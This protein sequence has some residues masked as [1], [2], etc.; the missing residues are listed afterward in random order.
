M[1]EDEL[2]FS[3]PLPDLERVQVAIDDVKD[4]E[5][6]DQWVSNN[7]WGTLLYYKDALRRWPERHAA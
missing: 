3:L 4:R 7:Y 1:Q 2:D 5:F 6:V